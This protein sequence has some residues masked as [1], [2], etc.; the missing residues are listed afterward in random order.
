MSIEQVSSRILKKMKWG[1]WSVSAVFNE[2]M[3]DEAA[4]RLFS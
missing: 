4:D 3:G 2:T 1:D